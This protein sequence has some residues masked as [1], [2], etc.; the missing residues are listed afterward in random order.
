LKIQDFLNLSDIEQQTTLSQSGEIVIK[1][2]QG[3]ITAN[4]YKLYDIIVKV[5]LTESSAWNVE[6]YNGLENIKLFEDRT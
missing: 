5:K 1:Y 4:V 3:E 2:L 6:V